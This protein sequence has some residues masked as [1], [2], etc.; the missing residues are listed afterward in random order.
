MYQMTKDPRQVDEAMAPHRMQHLRRYHVDV[1]LGE[2][3]AAANPLLRPLA[4]AVRTATERWAG[5]V[6][7]QEV[8]RRPAART[9]R[10][11]RR[12]TQLRRRLRPNGTGI[13]GTESSCRPR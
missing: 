8:Y 3:P 11:R 5:E 9:L 7:P 1:Q 2:L 6:A 10:L 4:A 12:R 13:G